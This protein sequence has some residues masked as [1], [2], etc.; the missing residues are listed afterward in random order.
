[1]SNGPAPVAEALACLPGTEPGA[2]P[3][4]LVALCLAGHGELMELHAAYLAWA[5]GSKMLLW[6]KLHPSLDAAEQC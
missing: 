1:M 5:Q 3:D 4:G 6:L 2:V